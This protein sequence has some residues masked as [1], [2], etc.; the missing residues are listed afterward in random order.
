MKANLK[1]IIDEFNDLLGLELPNS[2]IAHVDDKS[3]E[4]KAWSIGK[5]FENGIIEA[6]VISYGSLKSLLDDNLVLDGKWMLHPGF[7]GTFGQA[8]ESLRIGHKVTRSGWNGKGMFLWLKPGT[9]IKAEW[10]K[11]TKLKAIIDGNGGEMEGLGTICMKTADNKI[12]TG[13]L[14]SQTD[15]LA[16][17]WMLVD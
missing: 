5:H 3:G 8:I 14:A 16:N 1:P 12:L 9:T 4:I 10:C 15:I 13:W 6:G 17:D 2:V 11:D 7:C